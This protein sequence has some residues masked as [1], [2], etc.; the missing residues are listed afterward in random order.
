MFVDGTVMLPPGIW[1]PELLIPVAEA[2][3]KITWKKHLMQKFKHRDG[4]HLWR[5]VRTKVFVISMMKEL[6][7]GKELQGDGYV[8]TEVAPQEETMT[9]TY[10]PRRGDC[11]MKTKLCKRR[12]Y[13]PKVISG[14]LH[15]YTSLC[16][17][18]DIS[19]TSSG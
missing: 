19:I 12:K 1:Q 15:V 7:H 17:F 6:L 16:P 4:K 11:K 5:I 2:I 3:S 18:V 9:P 10:F 14:F 8:E 13:I